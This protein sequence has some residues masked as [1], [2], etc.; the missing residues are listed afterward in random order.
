MSSKMVASITI[1]LNDMLTAQSKRIVGSLSAINEKAKKIAASGLNRSLESITKPAQNTSKSFA[2]LD[3]SLAKAT[4]GAYAFNRAFIHPAMTAE[5]FSFALKGLYGGDIKQT[6]KAFTYL[7]EFAEKSSYG[8]EELTSGFIRLQ[9][10]GLEP[11]RGSLMSITDAGVKFGASSMQIENVIDAISTMAAMGKIEL[12]QIKRVALV[13]PDTFKL[14]SKQLGVSQDE[15]FK[16]ISAGELKLPHIRQLI[17]ALGNSARGSSDAFS[18][19]FIGTISKISDY[20]FNFAVDLMNSGPFQ[21]MAESV[22]AFLD[23]LDELKKNGQYK[24]FIDETAKSLIDFIKAASTVASVIGRLSLL[25]ARILSPVLDFIDAIGGANTVVALFATYVGIKSALAIAALSGKLYAL[26]AQAAAFA[27]SNPLLAAFMA[28]VAASG[29]VIANFEKI[30]RYLSEKFSNT[31]PFRF[32]IMHSGAFE[33]GLG[34]ASNDVFS[35]ESQS[36]ANSMSDSNVNITVSFD[37]NGVPYVP[38]VVK[39][40]SAKVNT[41]VGYL[42]GAI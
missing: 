30:R 42:M 35:R 2:L 14:L 3:S 26:T 41:R 32:D 19:S 25:F 38:S 23:K 13:I 37:K 21:A 9:A 36:R 28:I 7:R 15:L 24:K 20:W 5:R 22:N 33:K 39:T 10:A 12:E 31:K 4:I 6:Q 27:I 11:M 40:G 17:V 34:P 8:I 29:L 16:L 1:K 18:K